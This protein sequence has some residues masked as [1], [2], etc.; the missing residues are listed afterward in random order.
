MVQVYVFKVVG[1]LPDM[2]IF[3]TFFNIKSNHIDILLLKSYHIFLYHSW[4]HTGNNV[5]LVNRVKG[6]AMVLS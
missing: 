2:L 1:L 3:V 5:W 4:C 6:I